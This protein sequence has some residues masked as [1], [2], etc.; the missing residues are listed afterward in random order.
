MGRRT[1]VG[2]ALVFLVAGC[3]SGSS[4]LTSAPQMAAP[5]LDA[6]SAKGNAGTSADSAGEAKA[7]AES[8]AQNRQLVRTAQVDLRAEDVPA[9]FVTVKD[10]AQREG[11]YVGQESSGESGGSLT[12]RVPGDRL[13]AVLKGMGEIERT[14][15]TRRDVR[16]EDVTEQVVD[17]E[18]RLATQRASV[19]RVRA[20]LERAASTSEITQIEGE[21]TKRQTELESLQ[22]RYD[23]LK[24]QV[25]LS[26][27]TV[28]IGRVSGA[29]PATEEMGFLGALS[30]GWHAMLT[31]LRV[32][33]VVIGAVLPFA[34]LL[35]PVGAV[36]WLL[37]RRRRALPPI[38]QAS[39]AESTN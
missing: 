36:F 34:L 26:T 35:A 21:L 25:A 31:A 2:L 18:A 20:L 7:G 12:L 22:R 16:S 27:V 24:G 1:V 14:S 33:V 17:I 23:S 6:G 37:R 38:P 13:D 3:G 4:E 9:A 28:S 29:A 8:I 19:D 5:G 15:V 32:V 30:S 39:P 11:G 10:L